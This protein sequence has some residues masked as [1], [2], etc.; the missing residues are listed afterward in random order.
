[1]HECAC[2]RRSRHELAADD[3]APDEDLEVDSH[4]EV[5]D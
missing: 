1:M 2:G 4:D 3:V 5:E